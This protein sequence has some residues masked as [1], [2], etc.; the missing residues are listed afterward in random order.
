MSRSGLID[1]SLGAIGEFALQ[2]VV[3]VGTSMII[4]F[5]REDHPDNPLRPIL[6]NEL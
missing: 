2:F 6:D 3:A 5:L 1:G 4:T